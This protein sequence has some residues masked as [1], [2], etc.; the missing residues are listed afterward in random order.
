MT[1]N[2]KNISPYNKIK[3]SLHISVDRE[4]K[5]H[6][7]K[8]IL[9]AIGIFLLA[10]ALIIC[11]TLIENSNKDML[12]YYF[13]ETEQKIKDDGEHRLVDFIALA[14]YCG[15]SKKLESPNASFEINGTKAS[16]ISGSKTAKIN[17]IE[18]EMPTEASIKNGYCLVPLLTVEII[19]NGI[20]IAKNENTNTMRRIYLR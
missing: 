8:I 3:R 9:I 13:G 18:I 12:V 6:K 10:I 17:G 2:K 1:H 20:T 14:D 4:E 11:A 15:M 5:A 16:F 19:I 7:Q